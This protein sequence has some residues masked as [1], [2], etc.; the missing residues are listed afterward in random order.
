M[1]VLHVTPSYFPAFV[2][3]G[4][5][6]TTHHLNLALA[7]LGVTVRVLTTDANGMD[8]LEA[9]G[10]T[11]QYGHG[12]TV[13]YCRRQ[14][15]PDISFGFLW[16]LPSAVR[17]A[18][19]VHITA[20]YS[21]STIPALALSSWFGKPVFWSPRGAL[22]DWP[23]S[24]KRLVKWFWDRLCRTLAPRHTTIVAASA[25]EL[26][27]AGKKFPRLQAVQVGN[28]VQVPAE[29]SHIAG[30]TLRLLFL[31]R[32]HPIKGLENLFE[33]CASV[34]EPAWELVVAG[35]AEAGHLAFLKEQTQRLGLERQVRFIGEV[36]EEEKAELFSRSDILVLPSHSENFGM[37]VAEA[38]AHEV[39]VIVSQGA[40]WSELEA[41]GCGVWCSNDPRGLADAIAR[42]AKADRRVMGKK[43]RAWM[44]SDFGWSQQ[45]GRL[46]E[47]YQRAE[48]GPDV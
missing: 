27:A 24:P 43:G 9:S 34:K 33:A 26:A 19:V 5:I 45:A 37:V 11:V 30:K 46:L 4:P 35:P 32:I 7:E 36:N 25:L 6:R 12:L 14:F 21:L 40:P 42:M 1:K 28:G 39:P 13:E 16:R 18:D 2:Y 10:K 44:Q 20:V 3:G 23:G 31:G 48:S 22:Q 38:L 8:R 17:W 41:R 47:H 15:R 29:A